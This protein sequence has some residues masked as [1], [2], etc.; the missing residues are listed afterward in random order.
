[1]RLGHIPSHNSRAIDEMV[2]E[3]VLRTG[4][5]SHKALQETS[6]EQAPGLRLKL[7]AKRCC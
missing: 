5:I 4:D 7:Q 2:V 1:M 6:S 3:V